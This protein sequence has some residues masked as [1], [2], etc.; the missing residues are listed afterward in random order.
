M[1]SW[2][3]NPVSSL[4]L[5]KGTIALLLDRKYS[6]WGE[7]WDSIKDVRDIGLGS[8]QEK[9][10]DQIQAAIDAESGS[11][12]PT[13]KESLTVA[14][15]ETP[16]LTSKRAKIALDWLKDKYLDYKVCTRGNLTL[17]AGGITSAHPEPESGHRPVDLVTLI[18]TEKEL[19]QWY[20]RA[21]RLCASEALSTDEAMMRTMP[22]DAK[23]GE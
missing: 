8:N 19:S 2:R 22:G 18:A 11:A 7:V 14:E 10:R 4:K 1:T 12:E 13:V 16:S 15:P 23:G 5:P 6:T 9:V 21:M 3:T 20:A 17:F